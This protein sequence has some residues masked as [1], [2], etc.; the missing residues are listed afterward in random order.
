MTSPVVM[1]RPISV[2]DGEPIVR[3]GRNCW[4]LARAERVALLVDGLA[5]FSAVADAI[6]RARHSIFIVGWDFNSLVRMRPHCDGCPED[7]Q[8]RTLLS[9]ALVRQPDLAVYV[10]DWD[11]SMIYALERELLPELRLAWG[12]PAQF[13][14]ALDDCHP[15]AGAHH[16]KIV[17]VDDAMG[18]VGGFDFGAGR[19]DTPE[20]RPDDPRRIDPWGRPYPPLHDVQM[21][22]DGEAAALLGEVARARWQRATGERIPAAPSG[23][24][25]WPESVEPDF[26]AV[27]VAIARTM[28]SFGGEPEVREVE[29]LYVDAIAAARRWIYIENQYLTST[30]VGAALEQRLR[31]VDG[32]EIVIL[33]PRECQGWLEETTMGV[34]RARLMRRLLD[35]DRQHR[36]RVYYPDV[37]GLGDRRLTVHSKVLIIDDVLLRVGSANLNNRSMGVDTEC[38]LA[39]DATGS[40]PL[41][42]RIAQLRNRL[43]AEHVGEP[44]ER[45][46]ALLAAE[47]SLIRVVELL[48]SPERGLRLLDW[49]VEPWLDSIVPNAAVVDPERPVDVETLLSELMTRQV[50]PAAATR[51]LPQFVVAALAC[52]AGLLVT[53]LLVAALT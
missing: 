8:L 17:V 3:P 26:R 52:V 22:V 5:Y 41:A 42:A 48:S 32:P 44:I 53:V 23:L 11:F 16:Q 6:E 47:G 10:L 49:D 31:E 38:D 39:I 51:R 20:H 7:D 34:L 2:A 25:P 29:A 14:F 35:A 15:I 36:L 24:D 45:V 30:A 19:W 43:L 21:A 37:L 28:P 9:A 18:L 1:P 50:E 4:R 12:T 27:D 13:R 46:E 40:P 33:L